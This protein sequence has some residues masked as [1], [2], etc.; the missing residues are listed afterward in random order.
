MSYIE[1]DHITK[2]YNS[3][4][5]SIFCIKGCFFF[6]GKRRAGGNPWRFRGR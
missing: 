4:G 2:E 6:R 5:T 1:F 3:G